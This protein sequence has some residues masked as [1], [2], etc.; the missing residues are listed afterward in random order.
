M[1]MISEAFKGGSRGGG[2]FNKCKIDE[3]WNYKENKCIKK[4]KTQTII[5]YILLLLLIIFLI[6]IS[7]KDYIFI[8][9]LLILFI[10]I[11]SFNYNSIRNSL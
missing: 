5:S 10:I 1:M 2:G 3:Y 8:I 4:S 7:Y 11:I 6:I 9:L